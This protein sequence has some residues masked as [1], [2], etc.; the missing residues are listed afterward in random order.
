M[1]TVQRSPKFAMANVSRQTATRTDS[2]FTL[3]T[4]KLLIRVT[5]GGTTQGSPWRTL[6]NA[7]GGGQA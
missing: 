1:S 4:L 5:R 2:G 6:A 3:K 7:V